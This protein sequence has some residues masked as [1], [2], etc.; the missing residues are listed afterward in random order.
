MHR[1]RASSAVV[2]KTDLLAQSSSKVGMS[3]IARQPE[4]HVGEQ[5]CVDVSQGESSNADIDEIEPALL[6]AGRSILQ[7]CNEVV[8]T[9]TC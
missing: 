1:D 3:N 8:H 4:G 5:C 9:K 2:V 7:I 6:S